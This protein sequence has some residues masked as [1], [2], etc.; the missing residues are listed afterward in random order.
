VDCRKF[1]EQVVRLEHIGDL[2]KDFILVRLGQIEGMDLNKFEYDLDL[3]L[4]VFFLN[5]KEQIYGRFGGRDAHDPESRMSLAGLRAA[6]QAAL[7]THASKKPAVVPVKRTD[8]LYVRDLTGR[9]FRCVH[10]HQAKELY[11]ARLERQGKWTR[12]EV[13]RWPLPDNL[14]MVLDV[15]KGNALEKVKPDSPAARLGLKPG[16]VIEGLNGMPVH[17]FADAQYALDYAPKKGTVAVTWTHDGKEHTG[18]LALA[19]G[20][21]MTDI[22]W[23]PS[24][25]RLV[26]AA[27]LFGKDLT[28]GE[29][30][31]LGLGPGHLAFRQKD[32]VP[33]QARDAGIRPGDIILG[34][35]G[36]DLKMDVIN[37]LFYVRRHYLVGDTVTVNVVRD[38]KHLDL[39]MT[40]R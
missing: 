34:V 16:D 33:S 7:K 39:P 3:T 19:K 10:C 11:H 28:A 35:D 13:W 30:K 2:A 21:R 32:T 6:M 1:D 18:K 25:Y 15:D 12:D 26:P 22:S 24:V 20:W 8:P 23:R 29:K 37:F 27:R 40:L 31:A 36:K 9:R 14:G 17:S 4:A 5:A 38:G